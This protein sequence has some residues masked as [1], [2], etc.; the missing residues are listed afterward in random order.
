[1]LRVWYVMCCVWLCVCVGWGYV[2]C[3]VVCAVCCGCAVVVLCGVCVVCELKSL[4]YL[5]S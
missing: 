5:K 2:V 1:M 4:I 3:G